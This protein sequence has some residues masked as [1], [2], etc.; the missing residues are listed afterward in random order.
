MTSFLSSLDHVSNWLSLVSVGLLLIKVSPIVTLV[1]T[2]VWP[3]LLEQ[4]SFSILYTFIHQ[5]YN[6][7][8][9]ACHTL[10]FHLVQ[11]T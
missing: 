8:S 5:Q 7:W 9:R 2:F 11:K 1:L 4:I 10:R 3:L 6:P